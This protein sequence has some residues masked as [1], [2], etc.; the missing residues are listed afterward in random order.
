MAQS[1]YEVMTAGQEAKRLF[2]QE[3]T[4]LDVTELIC[5]EMNK[6]GITKAQLA[7]KMGVSRSAIT[8]MLAGERNMTLRLVS[9]ALFVLGKKLHPMIGRLDEAPRRYVSISVDLEGGDK[10]AGGPAPNTNI[11][12]TASNVLCA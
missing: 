1:V 10:W 2:Q 11:K 9:D 8:Q 7:K 6:Q 3:R 12:I 4:I 5:E